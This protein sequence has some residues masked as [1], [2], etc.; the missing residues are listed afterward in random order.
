VTQAFAATTASSNLEARIAILNRLKPWIR[1]KAVQDVLWSGLKDRE[2]SIRL[3]SAGLLRASGA[4]G[5]I[6][7]PSFSNASL[8][9]AVC[10]ALAASRDINAIAVLETTR[11]NIEIELFRKDAPVTVANF[12]SLAK[13]GSY[14]E[15]EFYRADPTSIV[16]AGD[17]PNLAGAGQFTCNEINMHSFARGSVGMALTGMDSQANRF[18]IALTPQPELDGLNTC[19]GRVVSGME[20]AERIVPGDRLKRVTIKEIINLFRRH[21]N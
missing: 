18:F 8:S 12:I 19:F 9:D 1:E 7:D 15:L 6:Q 10:I 11:G 5:I 2:R 4:G 21:R 16:E 3:I 17:P 14:G 13:R 20:V